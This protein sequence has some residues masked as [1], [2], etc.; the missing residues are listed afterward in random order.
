VQPGEGGAAT[1]RDVKDESHMGW[2]RI[3]RVPT[4]ISEDD[5]PP[6]PRCGQP[7][8]SLKQFRCL[9]WCLYYIAGA[10]WQVEYVRA[11]PGCMRR[12]LARR[13]LVNIIPANVL[14]PVLVLPWTAVLFASTYQKGHSPTVL[15][16]RLPE[17]LAAR[18]A[19]AHELSW[20]RVW[21]VIG[22][23]VCWVPVV[24]L[25]FAVL[26]Y[27]MN[28]KAPDW[29]RPASIVALAVSGLVHLAIVVFLV[30]GAIAE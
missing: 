19:A 17:Q 15:S 18:E 26:A 28:R 23:L 25:P 5:T 27:L 16:G 11:C 9:S 10:A 20:A 3:E 1:A 12:H 4:A 8:D 13:T 22:L 14:W 24:G 7:T 2:K 29:K 30:A 6:C 21:V